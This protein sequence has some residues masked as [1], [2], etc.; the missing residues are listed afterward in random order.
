MIDYE[1][2][3]R[4]AKQEQPKMI[5]SGFTAYPRKIDFK[6]FHEIAQEVGAYSFADISH[7][8]G[9]I[10]AGVHE[11]PLPFT[12]VVTTTTHK[13]L[14]GP[15]GAMIMCKEA[16][17]QKMDKAVFPLLQGGPHNHAV[18]AKAVAFEEALRPEFK[19][20]G[21]QIVSNARALA[22]KLMERGFRLV[23]GG[24]DNHLILIDLSKTGISG[25]D[26][27]ILLDR[28]GITVNKNAIPYDTRKPL[29]PSGIRMGTPILTTR[30]M[31]EKEMEHV[32]E[33]IADVIMNKKEPSLVREGV[34]ELCKEFPAFAW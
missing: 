15:R 16:F 17:A 22:E 34:A 10:A 30:G 7:I 21:E 31:K 13:T 8:A 2:I 24:T 20:Y 9:L 5:I 11:S 28:A 27:E 23:S 25:K 29:D 19:K 4:L 14:R 18:A 26:A 33:L 12:D 6:R 1:S 3:R 32:A